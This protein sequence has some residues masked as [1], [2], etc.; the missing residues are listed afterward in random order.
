MQSNQIFSIPENYENN[1]G[2][3]NGNPPSNNQFFAGKIKGKTF[4]IILCTPFLADS[5]I[6]NTDA[7]EQPTCSMAIKTVHLLLHHPK[8]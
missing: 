2:K 7:Q 5:Y 8:T 1:Y 3:N 4:K 6:Q